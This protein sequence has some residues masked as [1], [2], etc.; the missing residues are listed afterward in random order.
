MYIVNRN[1]GKAYNLSDYGNAHNFK[2]K[3]TD[4][5]FSERSARRLFNGEQKSI[6]EWVAKESIQPVS[7]YKPKERVTSSQSRFIVDGIA[8]ASQQEA[9]RAT[10][11]LMRDRK[12]MYCYA[13]ITEH[14]KAK[15][16]M[17]E[18]LIGQVMQLLLLHGKLEYQD[19]S[20]RLNW[21]RAYTSTK[22]CYMQDKGYVTI[23]KESNRKG[24]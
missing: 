10:R 2:K 22:L 1:T 6:G 23:A 17:L 3:V 4:F 11:E 15:G 12:P 18:G 9:E 13:V 14:G 8:Y 20:D 5:E 7:Y 21:S 16:R 19:I 24:I